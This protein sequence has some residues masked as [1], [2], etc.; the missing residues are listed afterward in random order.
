[1]SS[2][3][4]MGSGSVQPETVTKSTQTATPPEKPTAR[5]QSRGG[6]GRRITVWVLVVLFAILAPLTTLVAWAHRTVFDTGTYIDTVKPIASDP[7]VVSAVSARITNDIYASLDP[8]SVVANALPPKAAFLAGPIANGAKGYVQQ[9]VE[10]VVG[11]SQFQTLWVEANRFAHKEI[12]DV[13]RGNTTIVSTTNNEVVLNLVP[14]IAAALSNVGSFAS[15]VVGHPV[16][17]PQLTGTELP[18]AACAKLSTAIG[19]PLPSTCGQIVL[20]RANNLSDARRIAEAFDRATWAL[21]IVTPLLAAAAIWISRRRRRTV[22]QLAIGSL[23]GF[24]IVR[25]AGFRLQDSLSASGPP[26]GKE[27]RK[28]VLHQVLSGFYDISAWLIVAA[29]VVVFVAWVTGPYRAAAAVRRTARGISDMAVAAVQ[30]SSG[31]DPAALSFVRRH[32]DLLRIAGVAVAILLLLVIDINLIWFLVIAALLVLYEVGLTRLR[33][34][35]SV[36]LPPP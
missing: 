21:V 27:A 8:Q 14:L 32:Y 28:A 3:P 33:P 2:G 22:L 17:V 35:T 5:S 12:V 36:S 31:G 29:I 19:R 24:V 34:P 25:R 26:E 4:G 23:L 30:N 7:A 16:T 18:A 15:S 6:L 1:M 13:L 10:R 9:G 11:S 20:F